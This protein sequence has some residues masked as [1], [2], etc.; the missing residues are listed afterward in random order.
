M[1]GGYAQASMSKGVESRKCYEG[2]VVLTG[3]SAHP[4]STPPSDS[5]VS[6]PMV[7]KTRDA[8]CKMVR[9]YNRAIST[10]FGKVF[11]TKFSS[12]WK[13]G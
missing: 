2:R 12:V 5:Q 7:G 1:S 11:I 6:A 10:G 9:R 13:W 8:R 4:S 3:R